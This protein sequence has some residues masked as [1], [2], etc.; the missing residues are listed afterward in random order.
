MSDEYMNENM[1]AG[2]NNTSGT[3]GQTGNGNYS[4]STGNNKEGYHSAYSTGYQS[5]NGGYAGGTGNGHGGKKHGGGGKIALAVIVAAAVGLAG[6]YGVAQT[7]RS[8]RNQT[9]QSEDGSTESE[10]KTTQEASADSSET[11]GEESSEGSTGDSLK[12][13]KSTAVVTDV[14]QVVEDVMPSVVSVY[15]N[16]T[17]TTQDF[18][19]QTYAQ[20]GTSTGTGFI[21]AE[22]EDNDELLI[23]TNNHVV[24]GAD[25]LEVQFIDESTAEANIKGTDSSND[26]A[27]IAVKL[28]DIDSDTL[29]QIEVATLGSS[30]DLKI[31][32]PVVAIGNALGYGQSVTTG[33]VSALDREM[34]VESITGTF[35]QTDAAINPGNSGGPLVDL[36]GNVIGI[37]SSKIGGDT[38]DSMGFAIP[39]SRAVPII[40]DLMN[41]KTKTTVDEDKRGY[42]GISGVSVTSQVASAYS[43]P[44]GVYVAQIIE[45]GAAE[46]SDM[47]KG[48]IITALEGSTVSDMEELQKQLS[49]Y[50]S[51]ETV[52]IT[53]Q[54][55]DG[56]GEYSEKK[57]DVILGDKSTLSSY[58]ESQKEQSK[59]SKHSYGYNNGG[60]S[61][62]S[63]DAKKSD[64][65]STQDSSEESQAE[66][67]ES[68]SEDSG[69]QYY[70][71]PFGDLFGKN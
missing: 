66:E 62:S 44:E 54:R 32:E 31:G 53:V 41:Q 35:I 13:S 1:N 45:G 30:D 3:T 56:S 16:F 42:L 48:D 55:A 67:N 5:N 10:E 63:E 46:N 36:N 21:I 71:F 25:S 47:Q 9:A 38:V 8:G 19:G 58:E 70:S 22:D 20:E 61:K 6:G 33:V 28:S 23:A 50:E 24:D 18:F 7:T 39:I 34:T 64:E 17:Q 27:V 59:S 57:I 14:T 4:Y 15:N 52:T 65:D 11:T 29:S 40:Q 60:S 43:M 2:E 37:N 68:G 26:L 69:S 12:T 49:Y 51:G